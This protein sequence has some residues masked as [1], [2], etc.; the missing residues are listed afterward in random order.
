MSTRNHIPNTVEASLGAR[1]APFSPRRGLI[2][3]VVAEHGPIAAAEFR[4]YGGRPNGNTDELRDLLAAGLIRIYDSKRPLRYVAT[5]LE[6]VERQ[7]E[8]YDRLGLA[9]E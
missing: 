1:L 2:Y 5:P 8:L 6:D 3:A 4:K 7:Q 9:K